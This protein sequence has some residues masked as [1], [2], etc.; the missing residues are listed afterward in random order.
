MSVDGSPRHHLRAAHRG[1]VE[2]LLN[3]AVLILLI[4]PPVVAV[5]WSVI[6]SI[7]DQF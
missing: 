7:L 2:P 6:D 3:A 4:A 1:W 5:G